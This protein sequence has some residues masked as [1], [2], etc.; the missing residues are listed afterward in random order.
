MLRLNDGAS[1]TTLDGGGSAMMFLDVAVDADRRVPR[2]LEHRVSLTA[3][4]PLSFT[5]VPVRV[6]REPVVVDAPLRGP[7]WVVGN[8]CCAP[9]KA[10]RGATLSIDGTINVSERFAIDFRAARTQPRDRAG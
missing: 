6:G 2:R 3:G 10:H 8:G 5:G 1:G 9:P 4:A 7:G